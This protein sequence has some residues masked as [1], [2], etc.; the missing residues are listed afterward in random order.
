MISKDLK[1]LIEMCL[2]DGILEDHE[3]AAIIRR[4]E[5]EGAD[6]EEVQIYLNSEC[7]NEI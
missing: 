4:A 3:K 5:R 1:E 6:L 2:T 7:K